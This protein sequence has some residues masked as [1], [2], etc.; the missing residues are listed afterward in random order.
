MIQTVAKD[1]HTEWV[2]LLCRGTELLTSNLSGL[3]MKCSQG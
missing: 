2:C 1:N 3:S